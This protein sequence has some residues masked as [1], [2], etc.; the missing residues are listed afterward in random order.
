MLAAIPLRKKSIDQNQYGS[1]VEPVKIWL[2]LHRIGSNL[3]RGILIGEREHPI[4]P[5][6]SRNK[7]LLV[8]VLGH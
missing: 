7:R 6:A 8:S 4:R 5:T 2:R 3:F 1:G